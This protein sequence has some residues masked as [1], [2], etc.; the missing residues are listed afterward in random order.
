ML[1]N[2]P[3]Y[4]GIVDYNVYG[5]LECSGEAMPP[6]LSIMLKLS[7]VIRWPVVVWCSCIGKGVFRCSLYL[8][9]SV[10]ADS[11]IL[12]STLSHLYQYIIPLLYC[13]GYLSFGDTGHQDNQGIHIHKGQ[14]F[15][16]KEKHCLVKPSPY[17]GWNSSQHLRTPYQVPV[18]TYTKS[19]SAQNITSTT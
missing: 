15:H 3:V 4:G 14:Q 11:P 1:S 17:V 12:Q 10:I 16:P 13:M 18:R 2:V 5:C 9:L 6:S 8:S 7:M 19:S